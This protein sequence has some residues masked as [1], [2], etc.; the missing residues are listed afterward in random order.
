MSRHDVIATASGSILG[1]ALSLS[2]ALAA[3]G[4]AANTSAPPD[5]SIASDVTT[6]PDSAA[7]ADLAIEPDTSLEA[8]TSTEPDTSVAPD[9]SIEPDTAVDAEADTTTPCALCDA[10]ASIVDGLTRIAFDLY[11]SRVA[12]DTTRYVPLVWASAEATGGDRAGLA[13]TM[14]APGWMGRVGAGRVVVW[15]GHEGA[16]S[17]A[18][19]GVADNDAFRVRLLDWLRGGGQRVHVASGHGEWLRL[20][21]LSPAVRAALDGV[22]FAEL[23]GT[24]DAA[25]LATT[26][27]LVLGNPWGDMSDAELD[28]IATWIDGGGAAL[29]LGVGWS[30]RGSHDDPRA[31]RYPVQR[32]GQRLGFSVSDGSIFDPATPAGDPASP[33]FALRA[34]DAWRPLEV[35]VLT[36]DDVPRVAAEA[37]A[38]PAALFVIEGAHMG[39]ALP[40]ADWPLLTDPVAALAALDRIYLAELD[41]VGGVNPAFGG[42]MVWLVGVDAPDEPFWMHS[43][44]PIVYQVPAARSEILPNLATY[45]HPGWGIAHEQGHNM[46]SSSCADLYV[47]EGTGEVWPNVFGL[48]SYRQNGWDWAPQMGADLFAAGHA[49]HAQPAPDFA[50]L[51]ADPFVLLGCFDLL[52]TAH[53]WDGM[54]AFLTGAAEDAAAGLRIDDDAGRTAYLVERLSLAYGLDLAPLFAHWGFTV[55]DASRA[56]TSG[57]PLSDVTW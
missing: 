52:L 19:D 36:G 26:D 51:L 31:E 40:S 22:T 9:T 6:E 37:A 14:P 29:V 41:L 12:A 5:A 20:A 2:C 45:G 44:N 33:A 8:D 46:H 18:S 30:W 1:W 23:D 7:E 11:V 56:V 15:A 55:S 34:L 53:G 57:L 42:D 13:G 16:F 27:L 43:G 35:V 4:Q 38:H 48:W 10:H 28:A 3:C 25:A 32:L 17:G 24:L 50:D 47:V 54:R 21:D 49:Y 39:L